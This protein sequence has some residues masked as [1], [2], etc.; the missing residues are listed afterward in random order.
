MNHAFE[1]LSAEMHRYDRPDL[2]VFR[3]DR[4]KLDD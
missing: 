4:Q 3:Q 2:T 1:M